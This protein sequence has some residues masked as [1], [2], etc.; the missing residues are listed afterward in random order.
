MRDRTSL[1]VLILAVLILT[2]AGTAAV[3]WY[4]FREQQDAYRVWKYAISVVS[5]LRHPLDFGP[6]LAY[7]GF[8]P[9]CTSN[10]RS[11]A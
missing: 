7:L 4:V 2:V 8:L 6:E 1:L 11:V 10:R 9:L 3:V 5:L